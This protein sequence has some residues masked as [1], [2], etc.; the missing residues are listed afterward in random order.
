MDIAPLILA[1]ALKININILNESSTSQ[2]NNINIQ[3]GRPTAAAIALHRKDDHYNGIVCKPVTLEASSSLQKKHGIPSTTVR[4]HRSQLMALNSSKY[5]KITREVR[6][7][8]FHHNLWKPTTCTSDKVSTTKKSIYNTPMIQWPKVSQRGVNKQNLRPI[9]RVKECRATSHSSDITVCCANVRS[10]RNKTSQIA[11][12]IID[13]DIDIMALTESWLSTDDLVHISDMTPSGYSLV[14]KPRT[15]RPGGGI[16][17]I[18]KT[19]LKIKQLT[20]LDHVSFENMEFPVTSTN[21]SVRLVILY[22]TPYSQSHKVTTGVF[23][24]EFSEFMESRIACPGSLV[25]TGDF[26]LRVNNNSDKDAQNFS[27]LLSSMQLKQFIDQP[28]HVSGNTLDLLI[29]RL[30]DNVISDIDIDSML[31]DH[32]S[33][34]FHLKL[35]KP[36]KKVRQITFRRTRNIDLIKFKQDISKCGLLHESNDID[37]LA[38]HYNQVLTH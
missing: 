35:H 30:S 1:N 17:L 2:V 25:I 10:A 31:S 14:Q 19:H 7:C 12:Y 32:W 5:G 13:H 15:D 6:K 8:L 37:C 23:L 24:R 16:A 36:P 18:F 34:L 21:S 26:N 4:Y 11:N 33:L 3:V 29:S 9:H 22:R 38:S 20:S 27:D 28:T